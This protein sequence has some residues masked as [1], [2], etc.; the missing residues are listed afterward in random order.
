MKKEEI[1]SILKIDAEPSYANFS[2]AL[3]LSKYPMLGV[4]LPKL[5]EIAKDMAK[6]PKESLSFTDFTYFE[7]V[8]L[9]GL[10]I[11]YMK[12]NL[13]TKLLYLDKYLEFADNW[14]HVDSVVMTLKVKKAD[15]PALHKKAEEYLSSGKEFYVRTGVL[16][17]MKHFLAN[18]YIDETLSR[19][20]EIDCGKYYVSMAVAWTL[21][22]AVIKQPEKAIAF[23][24][25][26]SLDRETVNRAIAK[27]RD[28]FRI[29]DKNKAH[30]KTLKR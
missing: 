17:L 16:F 3:A 22:E 21:C 20:N 7:E 30:L 9:F 8:M 5:R 11:V 23:L 14:S 19:L 12:E 25:K 4:R 18:D 29:S 1:L 2:S 24:E 6:N 26:T 10:T 13:D 28:S 15:L 27:C